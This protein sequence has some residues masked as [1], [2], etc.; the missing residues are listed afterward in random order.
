MYNIEI[1]ENGNVREKE[2][3]K[4]YA[5]FAQC[6]ACIYC[7]YMIECMYSIYFLCI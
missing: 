1:N 7:A 2:K 4:T 6:M 5:N 3:E